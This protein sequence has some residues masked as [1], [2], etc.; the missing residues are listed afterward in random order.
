MPADNEGKRGE[1]KMGANISLYTVSQPH[2]TISTIAFHTTLPKKANENVDD[3]ERI[4][5]Y[6]IYTIK[7][8]IYYLYMIDEKAI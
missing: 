4:H 1:N 5:G 2:L 6:N 8:K 7:L 3:K